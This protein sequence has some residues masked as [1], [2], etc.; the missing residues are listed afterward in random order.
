MK[1]NYDISGPNNTIDLVTLNIATDDAIRYAEYGNYNIVGTKIIQ[2]T[3]S[4]GFVID[5]R[6]EVTLTEKEKS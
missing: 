1:L 4:D 6:M 2:S 3:A 5:F